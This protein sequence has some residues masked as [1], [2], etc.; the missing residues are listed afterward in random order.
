MGGNQ[1][2]L[3]IGEGLLSDLNDV[4]G[5]RNFFNRNWARRASQLLVDGGGESARIGPAELLVRRQIIWRF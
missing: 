5:M 4:Q 2:S 3:D 1:R